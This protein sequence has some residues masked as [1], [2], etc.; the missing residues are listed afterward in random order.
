MMKGAGGSQRLVYDESGD[1]FFLPGGL[2]FFKATQGMIKCIQ[3]AKYSFFA[4]GC[5]LVHSSPTMCLNVC[6]IKKP[7]KGRP[8]V[9]TGL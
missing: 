9:H 4:T 7:Q 1:R 3:M 5:S 2:M 6:V 8:K